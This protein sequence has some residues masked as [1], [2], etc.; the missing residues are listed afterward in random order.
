MKR[1]TLLCLSTIC[2]LTASAGADIFI[3]QQTTTSAG[4][5]K[6][7]QTQTEENRVW[8]AADK[9]ANI[10][11]STSMIIRLDKNVA[12][13]I[14]NEKKTYVEI[15][16]SSLATS[17][18]SKEQNEA[19]EQLPQMFAGMMKMAVSVEPTAETKVIRD[20]N[21]TKYIQT[22]E[23]A[24]GKTQSEMWA[25]EDIDVSQ[26]LLKT[27][28]AAFLAQNSAFKQLAADMMKETE[29]IKGYVVSSSSYTKM[30]GHES[31]STMEVLEVKESDP[32]EGIY[33][34]PANFKKRRYE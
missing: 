18:M 20:W 21:C 16:L 25:T 31:R 13:S 12:Y 10:G 27:F 29:K 11:S 34:V 22:V 3:R 2:T 30:M 26:D 33:E 1:T 8:I 24:G 19:M 5:A 14:N 9:M 6:N 17:D 15:P 32:P 4:S 7:E 28:A 23:M